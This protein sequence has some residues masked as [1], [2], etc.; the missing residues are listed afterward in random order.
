LIS[1]RALAISILLKTQA[2]SYGN[3]LL[4]RYLN[5]DI[6]QKDR[7]LVTELVNGVIQ[8]RLR[9]DYIIS[10]F[11]KIQLSKLSPFVI[12]AI[13]L[14][15]YQAFFL[16]RVPDFA[17]V[18]ESVDL[19]KKHEGKRAANFTN[20]ILRNA[21]RKKDAISYPNKN[22]D[23]KKY[24]SVYY[25]FPL[26]LVTRWVELF[27][28]DFTIGLCKALNER[29]KLCIRINTLLTDKEALQRQL[30]AEGVCVMPGLFTQEALYILDSPPIN[31]LKSFDDGLF[32]PQDESSIIASLAVGVESNDK[33]LDVAAAPGGKTTHMAALMENKGEII[34]WDIHPHRIKLIEQNSR[35]LK[36]TIVVTQVRDAKIPDKDMFNKFDKVI[37]DAP[38]SGLGVIRRKP[39][40]KWSKKPEDI[41]AL[42][43]EQAKILEVCSKYVKPGGFLVYSTCS[44]DPEENEKI[45]EEFLAKNQHFTYDDLRPYLPEKLCQNVERL[46]GNITLY[47][48]IHGTDGFFI[49]RLKKSKS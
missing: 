20:A 5:P 24:L 14:G 30:S 23:I 34:A 11:S 22:T 13:R 32:T 9:L 16:D 39:D 43:V 18:N 3:L 45:V 48:N 29:P 37:I 2:G 15:L 40:I 26:W 41:L 46:Y 1:P 38:C 21:L 25:S 49:A 10:Q 6:P 12:N 36:A 28:S 7:A 44:I 17:A 19:V 42:K 35:R 27:G 33:V 31:H 4:N 47:P 8:N